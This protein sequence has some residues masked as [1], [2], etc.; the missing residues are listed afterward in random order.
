M[1]RFVRFYALSESVVR[2]LTMFVFRVCVFPTQRGQ[3]SPMS[4]QIRSARAQRST[5][6]PAEVLPC[7]V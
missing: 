7:A 3:S 6:S 5:T 4:G 1:V 2:V